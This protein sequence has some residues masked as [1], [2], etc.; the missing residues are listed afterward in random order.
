MKARIS[1]A[2][3]FF[4]TYFVITGVALAFAGMAGYLQFRKYALEEVDGNLLRQA[5]LVSAMFRPFLDV[6][7]PDVESIAREGDRVGKDLDIRLTV[8]LPDGR[9][10]ADSGVGAGKIAGM[11]NHADRPEV[12]TALSGQTGVSL[13]RSITVRE[14]DRYLAIPVYSGER[15][16]GAVR[17]SIPVE[18]LSRRLARVRAITW[19][20]GIVAFLLMLAGTAIRARHVTGPLKEMTAAARELASGN[21]GKRIHV[22]TG[23]ELE[24]TAGAMNQMAARLEQTISQSEAGKARLATLLENLSEGVIVVSEGRT[25]RTMNRKAAGILGVPPQPVEGRPVAEVIRHPGVLAF[26]DAWKRGE[27]PFPRETDIPSRVGDRTVLLSGTM[28]RY[29]SEEG[30]DLLLTLRDVTDE[31]RLARIKSD[32]VSNASHELRTP[33]TN[34]RGYLEAMQDAQKEGAPPD[35]TFLSIAHANALRMDRL[36]E[37]LLELSRAESGQAPLEIEEVPL[38]A[39]LEHVASLHRAAA[40][41]AGKILAVRGEGAT[42]RADTRQLTLAVSNLL[43]NAIKHGRE[44]GHIALAGRS[45][46]GA[47]IL[48]VTDDGPGIPPEH[49]PRI[50]ERFYRVDKGRSRD[51]G[52]TGLGLSI[53]KHIVESHGGTIRAESGLGVGTRFLIRIPSEHQPKLS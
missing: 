6:P 43:D 48:E 40:E 15:I 25:F 19:G 53:A 42:L 23:D 9:V 7:A 11:E 49:L 52:G 22:R 4:L 13:R 24:E 41:R 50:F 30:A 46:E 36:I 2:T 12:H 5:R 33:L 18:F 31:R 34:I 44:G 17:T 32:F 47:F 37:D 38:V 21:L 51:L 27:T 45:E 29:A 26:F 16:V 8:I 20:T 14:E 39:F 1:I 10:A 3:K 28:V 35:P